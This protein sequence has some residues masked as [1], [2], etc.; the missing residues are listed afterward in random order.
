MKKGLAIILLAVVAVAAYFIFFNKEE[1]QP[2]APK[3][4]PLAQ[5]KNSD[6]F[7]IPFNNFLSAYYEL[8]NALVEWDTAAASAGAAKLE[9]EAAK[10]PYEALS[11]DATI[12]STAKDFSNAVVAESMGIRGEPTIEGKRRSFFTLSENLYNLIRTVR[13]DQQVIYHVK[14]P[15]AF[16]D[17]EEAY[18]LSNV[19]EV[20]NPY[21]GKKHPKYHS[22][23][24]ACGSITD[25]VDYRQK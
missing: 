6:S 10:I 8:K 20:I 21:L 15:M 22:G 2:A 19:N 3:Q 13:Y 1:A 18:W 24:L 16:N 5:S 14:C 25:S 12:V 4:Q 17:T 7:N 11:A 23:M 9:Q